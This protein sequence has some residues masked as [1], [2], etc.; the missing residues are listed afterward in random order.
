[1]TYIRSKTFSVCS[2]LIALCSLAGAETIT[3]SVHNR[4]RGQVGAGDEVILLRLDQ[5]DPNHVSLNRAYLSGGMQEEARTYSNSEGRFTLS[6][7]HPDKPHLVRVVHQGVNYDRLASIGDASSVDVF[8]AAAA[9]PGITG[10]IEIIRIGSNR[11]LLHVSDMIEIK[12]DSSPPLTQS[13]NRTF[14]VYLPAH[15]KIDSVL[16]ASSTASPGTTAA[17][18][19]AMPVAGEPGHY[20]VNFPLRPGATKFAFNYDLPYEGHATFRPKSMY[21]LQQ[22]AVMIPP[23]MKFTSRSPAFQVLRTGNDRY[24]V[25]AANVVKKGAGPGFEISG[26]DVLPVLRAQ[27]QPPTKLPIA[28]QPVAA[29]TGTRA[30][31]QNAN[32][33]GMLAAPGI[34]GESAQIQSRMQWVLLG[35]SVVLLGASGFLLWHRQCLARNKIT[36]AMQKPQQREETTASLAEALKGELRQLEIDRSLG[37]ITLEEYATAKQALEGTVKRA[38]ARAGAG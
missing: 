7:R 19:S 6:V 30:P 18:I 36:K 15:T 9:V 37:A 25:E 4:T 21:P 1:M 31:T 20:T 26:V 14:E 24:Q 8:D 27:S 3:G 28:D 16:A 35:A 32:G 38:L 5:A 22:L 29:P 17:L 34:L 2:G 33:L 10:S 23:T 12:N 11:S 13:G